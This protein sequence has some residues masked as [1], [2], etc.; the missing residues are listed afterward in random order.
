MA[1]EFIILRLLKGV[2]FVFYWDWWNNFTSFILKDTQAANESKKTAVVIRILSLSFIIYLLLPAISINIMSIESGFGIFLLAILVFGGI[3]AAT[4]HF[5]TDYIL[6]GF[7]A[8]LIIWIAIFITFFGWNVGVQH[9]LMVLLVLTFFAKYNNLKLKAIV[10]AGLCFL[11][12]ILYF[13]FLGREPLINISAKE[14]N[15]LQIINTIVIFW[16][17]SL[18]A[19]MYGKDSQELESK[20]V[21]YNE[22]LELLANTDKLT[23]LFN[24]RK[25]MEYI[26]KCCKEC[27][28]KGFCLCIC[29]IDFFKKVNDTYGHD[30]GDKVLEAIAKIFKEE[31]TDKNMAARWGGEE[32]LLLF[33]DCNGD[34]AFVKLCEIRR[35]IKDIVVKKGDEEIRVTM[36][37]GLAEYDYSGNHESMLTMADK[38]LYRGKEDGRDRIVY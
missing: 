18:V 25:A 1:Y 6:I 5:K 24:R 11:R 4:Y 17:M 23:S 26:E 33:P 27:G 7:C 38:K 32:F 31:M 8:S 19:Y 20:L 9:F 14:N 13:L 10:A 2:L 36:T 29:D 34:T 16:C 30:T 28:D 12:I 15:S 37:F 22:E 21:A 3:F 35:K